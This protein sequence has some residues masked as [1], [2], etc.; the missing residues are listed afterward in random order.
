MIIALDK[1][2][3]EMML[4]GEQMD[5]PANEIKLATVFFSPTGTTK[6]VVDY[7]A[8]GIG[9]EIVYSADLTKQD[10]REKQP[11][12]DFEAVDLI[13]VGAPTYG[14]F[15]YKEFRNCIKCL[16]FK[17]KCVIAVT[18]YGNAS[19][20][21]ATGEMI[22]VI[23]KRN[24]NLLGYGEFVGEHSYSHKEIP[25]AEGRPNADDLQTAVKFGKAVRN[26][27]LNTETSYSD[28]RLSVFDKIISFIAEIKPVHTGKR[29]FT[30]PKTDK[31]KCI[32]CSKCVKICP[33]SCINPDMT[34]V[35]DE[36]IVCMACVKI[37]P[38]G[39]RTAYPKNIII[40]AGLKLINKRKH[41][42]MFV[43]PK[44]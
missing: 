10:N 6:K 27:L 18:L 35:K 7:I 29:I 39:A 19:T 42:S 3:F 1:T 14:G 8:E 36:C 26:R 11:D 24:G 44:P 22:S 33:K 5:M 28:N 17:G 34:T 43:L 38:T 20:I 15:L 16:D 37:C 31:E 9:G 2:K 40:K 25:V 4:K 12:L 32:N 30:I 41:K 13:I 21:F 23:K